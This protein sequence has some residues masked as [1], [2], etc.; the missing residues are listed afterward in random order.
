MSL[1]TLKKKFDYSHNILILGC[2]P[3]LGDFSN[4]DLYNIVN[5][6]DIDLVVCIKQS[7]FKYPFKCIHVINTCN[8]SDYSDYHDGNEVHTIFQ[9]A[10]PEMPHYDITKYDTVLPII[11]VNRFEWSLSQTKDLERWS[12]KNS[13]HRCWGPG[14]QYEVVFYLCQFLNCKNIYTI[15]WDIDNSNTTRPH[16]YNDNDFTIINKAQPLEPKE[17]QMEIELSRLFYEWLK[18]K[19]INLQIASDNSYAHSSIPRIKL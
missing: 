12:F 7:I 14:L 16:F 2:G 6:N 9:I 15:G 17:T 11:N 8:I 4:N 5:K 13:K 18:S 3:S 19:S 1:I 10:Y